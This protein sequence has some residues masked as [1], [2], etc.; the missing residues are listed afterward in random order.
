VDTAR[1]PLL[2]GTGETLAHFVLREKIGEGGMGLVYRAEDVQLR[3]SVALKV[4]KPETMSDAET[5]RR[6]LREARTAAAL[7][8]PGIAT[9]YEVGEDRGVAYLAMELVQGRS[10]RELI[11]G[12]GLD[13]LR[14]IAITLDVARALAHAHSKGIVHRDL[15]PENVLVVEGSTVKLVD[16]GIAKPFE[17]PGVARATELTS[18]EHAVAG[19]PEYM[20]P[21]QLRGE[22]AEPRSDVFSLGVML[23][24]LLAGQ[25]PFHRATRAETI[26]AVMRDEAPALDGPEVPEIVTDLV[27]RCLRREATRRPDANEVVE[28]LRRAF[29][30]MST[31]P[32]QVLPSNKSERR[33][34]A[35]ERAIARGAWVALAMALVGGAALVVR[36][37]ARTGSDAP[38]APSASAA[39]PAPTPLRPIPELRERRLTSYDADID[40]SGLALSPRGDRVAYVGPEGLVV[41][42]LEGGAPRV[43]PPPPGKTWD[44]AR[45]VFVS[46]DEVITLEKSEDR[47]PYWRVPLSGGAPV[48]LGDLPWGFFS[49][50]G[51]HLAYGDHGGTLWVPP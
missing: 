44:I 33:P 48:S 9:V 22:A 8:H 45:P 47:S 4:L 16:F 17:R 39:A 36:A 31:A 35:R 43:V 11:V 25:R 7:A 49:R 29:G 40:A 5:R 19:T 51:A 37:R 20:A 1:V 27:A 21:E 30:A 26:A 10:L 28:T 32:T 13:V 3:R 2:P 41:R 34:A 24:E 12:S 46:D 38:P 50:D 6:F 23:H 14:G 18:Q 42:S 15:K